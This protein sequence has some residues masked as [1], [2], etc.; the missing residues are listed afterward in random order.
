MAW[1]AGW[2]DAQTSDQRSPVARAGCEQEKKPQD[3]GQNFQMVTYASR[4]S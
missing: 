2:M 3:E 1:E 4:Q